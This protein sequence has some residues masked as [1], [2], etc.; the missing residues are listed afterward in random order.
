MPEGMYNYGDQ[1]PDHMFDPTVMHEDNQFKQPFDT[2]EDTEKLAQDVVK[3]FDY[4]S[5]KLEP[6]FRRAVRHHRL[7]MAARRDT[8]PAKQKWRSW[9]HVP[10]PFS[11]IRTTSS[12]MLDLLF[13]QNPPIRPDAVGSE[14]EDVALK[15]E[16]LLDYQNRKIDLESETEM[17]IDE[18]LIIG[19]AFRKSVWI[20]DVKP[21]FVHV[22]QEDST[23]FEESVV[24][25]IEG[26][27]PMPPE[28]GPDL[29]EEA[30]AEAFEQWRQQAIDSGFSVPEPP[31]PGP[32]DVVHYRGTGFSRVHFWDMFYDPGIGIWK[33]QPCIVQRSLKPPSWV[34][35]RAGEGDDKV[36]DPYKV[37]EALDSTPDRKVSQYQEEIQA[38]MDVEGSDDINPFMRNAVEILECFMPFDKQAP[39]RVVLNR[40]DCINK[41]KSMPYWHGEDPYVVAQNYR[42]AGIMPGM[43]ELHQPERLYYELDTIRSLRLDGV[44]LSVL[45]MFLKLKEA[46]MVELAK[47]LIPGMIMEASRSDAVKQVTTIEP[48]QASYLEIDKIKEDINET[49]A[50]FQNV[51][52]GQV[53]AG[54]A[55]ESERAYSSAM[56]RTKARMKRF[57]KDLSRWTKH[58]LFNWYQFS[59][60]NERVRVGGDPALD[61]FVT[62]RRQEFLEALDMDF[63]FRGASN[64]L[65][66]DIEVQQLKDLLITAINAGVPEVKIP[67]I[68]RDIFMKVTRNADKYFYTAE[69]MEAQQAA[70]DEEETAGG[71]QEPPPEEGQQ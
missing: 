2:G 11:G 64:S 44:L 38:M 61:P 51:R 25:A 8:R 23:E 20:N 43:S 33:K 70:A 67:A 69:E 55:T 5:K 17:F 37:Q 56:Q 26:G 49:N 4:Y 66:R 58:S 22:N 35:D 24:M 45:P 21:I 16:R 13:Q 46:G 32:Q 62:Y 18:M 28:A 29:P 31:V 10:Y 42:V 52:G 40:Q 12:A 47:K 50:T 9:V 39:Y 3:Y 6:T 65:N 57:E 53:T 59:N 30:V 7:Y 71:G 14:D 15:I 48:P 19:L 1:L 54:T 27:M 63:A 68:L 60:P 34:K 41:V 36:F